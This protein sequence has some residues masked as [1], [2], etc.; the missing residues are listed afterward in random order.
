[1]G[2]SHVLFSYKKRFLELA[3][4]STNYSNLSS[5]LLTFTY[6]EKVPSQVLDFSPLVPSPTR[7]VFEF[8]R[9]LKR[10]GSFR[11]DISAACCCVPMY[12][13]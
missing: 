6:L 9:V 2:V 3:M 1:M 12:H 4:R 13:Q 7:I 8:S 5:P 10:G 11:Y